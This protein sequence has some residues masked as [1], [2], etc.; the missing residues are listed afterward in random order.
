[1]YTKKQL[2]EQINN[3]PD[4][5]IIAVNSNSETSGYNYPQHL[6]PVNVVD[7]DDPNKWQAALLPST[8]E[9]K[10]FTVY[11]LS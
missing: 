7:N 8:D 6:T 11:V 2:L 4:D 1:M 5:A 3:L 10:S 9:E